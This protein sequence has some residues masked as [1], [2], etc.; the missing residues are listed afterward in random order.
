MT[1]FPWLLSGLLL[2][3][4][5]PAGF[6]AEAYDVRLPWALAE[7]S[8]TKLLMTSRLKIELAVLDVNQVAANFSSPFEGQPIEPSADSVVLLRMET[9]VPGRQSQMDVYLDAMTD[10]AIELRKWET[11]GG[12]EFKQLR[13]TKTG[14]ARL[15]MQPDKNEQNMMPTEWTIRRKEFRVYPEGSEALSITA[16]QALPYL[17]ATSSLEWPGDNVEFY[18]FS[19]GRIIRVKATADAWVESKVN[20]ETAGTRIKGWQK[21]LEVVLTGTPLGEGAPADFHLF[22]LSGDIRFLLDVTRRVAIEIRGEI[23]MFGLVRFKL[24]T[25]RATSLS[26]HSPS[27]S[28]TAP[29]TGTHHNQL[30][31]LK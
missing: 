30:Q 2:C 28:I 22:G 15:R 20:F 26:A 14:I 8:A 18:I 10:E 9:K 3:V 21:T 17:I 6:A 19:D 24:K 5:M 31:P 23:A 29:G 13:Y 7:Y 1:K 4:V 12:H 27:V 11:G 25:L 16:P